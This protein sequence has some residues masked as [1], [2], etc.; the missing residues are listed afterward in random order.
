MGQGD[1]AYTEVSTKVKIRS[2]YM[3]VTNEALKDVNF[4]A[5]EINSELLSDLKLDVDNQLL[6]GDGTGVNLKGIM[7]YASAFAAGSFALNVVNPNNAD[8]LRVAINQI[9]V[10]GKMKWYPSAILMHP[11]DVA[12][13]DELKIPDGSYIE[14]PFYDGENQTVVKVPIIMNTGIAVGDFLVA[15]FGRAKAFVRDSMSIRIYNQNEDD[16]IKNLATVTANVRLAFRIK[17]QDAGA[18]VKGDFASAITAL[19]KA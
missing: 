8:V 19:T 6:N 1:V 9:M 7:Q 10:A 15:D 14:I 18:F 5:S 2:E 3:K 13:L 16:A 11:D 4:L 12:S 17:N